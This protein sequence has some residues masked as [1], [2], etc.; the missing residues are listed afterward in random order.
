MFN[1]DEANFVFVLAKSDSLTYV[2]LYF[3]KVYMCVLL[4]VMNRQ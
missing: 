2:D 4:K 3:D 1:Q